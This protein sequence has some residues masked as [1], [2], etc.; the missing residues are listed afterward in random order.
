MLLETGK[1]LRELVLEG[2]ATAQVFENLG[3]DYCCGGNR[4]LSEACDD[5]KIA[6]EEVITALRKARSTPLDRDWR[7]AP[8][9]ELAQYIVAKHHH[10]TREE[11]KRLLPLISTVVYVHGA[12]HPELLGIQ[13]IFLELSQQVT[14]HMMKEEEFLFPYVVKMEAAENRKRPLAPTL[15]AA[16]RNAVRML[17]KEHESS[18]IMLQQI[19]E[20]ARGYEL[21][22]GACFSYRTL[23][24]ALQAFEADLYRHIY[25]ENSI[26]FPRTL[27]LE[28]EPL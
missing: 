3:I 4:S 14:T 15:R 21:P 9:S 6:V 1:S 17:T 27:K 13:S 7:S 19:R 11:I 8:L 23:Y 18:S 28:E 10:F 20:A 26:V 25:L 12:D 22:L 2:P 16:S 5:A 24:Q